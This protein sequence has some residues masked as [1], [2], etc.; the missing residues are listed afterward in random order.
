[1]AKV[2]YRLDY[3]CWI[4]DHSGP[5]NSPMFP[6]S[7]GPDRSREFSTTHE[8]SRWMDAMKSAGNRFAD[9]RIVK[10]E[11]TIIEWSE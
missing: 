6:P 7:P 5:D 11:E 9:W 2:K 4:P 8:L 10:L 3:R 1:M